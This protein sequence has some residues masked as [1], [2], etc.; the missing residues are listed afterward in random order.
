MSKHYLHIVYLENTSDYFCRMQYC[1]D[2]EDLAHLE[3]CGGMNR[4]D[5]IFH[6]YYE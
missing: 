4:M 5:V 6:K 2:G 1:I 3:G